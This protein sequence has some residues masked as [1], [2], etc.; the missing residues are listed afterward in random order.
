MSRRCTTGCPS[1]VICFLALL[2]YRVLRMRLK[3]R[4]NP[5]LPRQRASCATHGRYYPPA[6][7]LTTETS[8][9]EAI[10]GPCNDRLTPECLALPRAS[11]ARRY[12]RLFSRVVESSVALLHRYDGYT[13]A[14][15]KA[16]IK[17][18]AG[19]AAD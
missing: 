12:S 9:A 3:D 14:P 18:L 11:G 1:A 13:L 5:Y 4:G 6:P 15:Q 19:R 2:L 8:R 7:A 10:C 16:E 17:R